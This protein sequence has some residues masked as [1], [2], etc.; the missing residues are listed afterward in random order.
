MLRDEFNRLMALFHEGAEGKP[1]N[2]EEVF[3]QSLMFFEHLKEQI[4]TGSPEERKEAT[5]MMV[6][7]YQ[8]MM[9]ETKRISE[10]SGLSEEQLAS[11]AE[12]PSNFTQEQW[13]AIQESKE[14]IYR[15]GQDLA[16]SIQATS[17]E[18]EPPPAAPGEK[19]KPSGPNPHKPKVPK[20]SQ[21]TRS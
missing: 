3:A 5:D 14:K 21:W 4:R 17:G 15:A 13:R 8:Q 20:K 19:K 9:V 18:A 1:I 10:R 16:K 7:M 11:Y 6:Q 2:I 12:N